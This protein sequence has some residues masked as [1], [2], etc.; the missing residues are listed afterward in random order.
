MAFYT[1]NFVSERL[2]RVRPPSAPSVSLASADLASD[3][4][5][6][7]GAATLPGPPPRMASDSPPFGQPG[8]PEQFGLGDGFGSSSEGPV[9]V[10][11]VPADSNPASSQAAAEVASTTAEGASTSSNQSNRLPAFLTLADLQRTYVLEKPPGKAG[12]QTPQ[13]DNP[14]SLIYRMSVSTKTATGNLGKLL[15]NRR[16]KDLKTYVKHRAT[17]SKE[18]P[19][20]VLG[21]QSITTTQSRAAGGGVAKKASGQSNKSKEEL[22]AE[23]MQMAHK[24]IEASAARRSKTVEVANP[25]GTAD[26][27]LTVSEAREAMRLANSEGHAPGVVVEL[28]V[29][30]GEL[31]DVAQEI[32]GLCSSI[33]VTLPPDEAAS[34]TPSVAAKESEWPQLPDCKIDLDELNIVLG[35]A[36]GSSN[37]GA[38]DKVHTLTA[39]QTAIWWA[40]FTHPSSASWA[41]NWMLIENAAELT[42]QRCAEEPTMFRDKGTAAFMSLR[43]D[44]Q[45]RSEISQGASAVFL[46]SPSEFSPLIVPEE[47][48][49]GGQQA[50]KQY[51]EDICLNLP[52]IGRST[53]E[54]A[55]AEQS[56]PITRVLINWAASGDQADKPPEN[57]VTGFSGKGRAVMVWTIWC[58]EVLA[59]GVREGGVHYSVSKKMG[60]LA[61]LLSRRTDEYTAPKGDEGK[62]QEAKSNR[63]AAGGRSGRGGRGRG[64]GSGADGFEDEGEGDDGE[65]GDD[66]EQAI[67][68]AAQAISHRFEMGPD[69]KR[70]LERASTLKRCSEAIA[71][72]VTRAERDQRALTEKEEE[73]CTKLRKKEQKLSE[74]E[75]ASLCGGSDASDASDAAAEADCG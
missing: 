37:K 38:A 60:T 19:M 3:L 64:R 8:F 41:E 4:L 67:K 43:T 24:Q 21:F 54:A 73:Q 25:L 58:L 27:P 46:K 12:L 39:A 50:V 10:V 62:P 59:G 51:F 70:R 56:G 53:A 22:G 33:C 15:E 13:R 74:Q 26:Y 48:A 40:L 36:Y 35:I 52:L 17:V 34:V 57:F 69:E 1:D 72:I 28:Q 29:P 2:R 63:A 42:G 75:A 9:P 44:A 32:V 71:G 31:R 45:L 65:G 16:Q 7:E 11:A 6:A 61:D 20:E 68:H 55:V 18:A 47:T 66:G 30:P 5:A 14:T 23:I 49:R